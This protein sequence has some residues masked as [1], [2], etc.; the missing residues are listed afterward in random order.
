M[1]LSNKIYQYIILKYDTPK[2]FNRYPKYILIWYPNYF[3]RIRIP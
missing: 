3:N 2:Y 1:K